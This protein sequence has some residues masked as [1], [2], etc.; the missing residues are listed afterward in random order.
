MLQKSLSN[1]LTINLGLILMTA[2]VYPFIDSL[3]AESMASLKHLV[4]PAAII[5][6]VHTFAN[7]SIMS[8]KKKGSELPAK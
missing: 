7:A 2:C 4:A 5:V 8:Q 6:S 3:S 1:P